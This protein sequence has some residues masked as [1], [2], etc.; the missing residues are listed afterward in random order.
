MKPTDFWEEGSDD[1]CQEC[2]VEHQEMRDWKI[3][4]KSLVKDEI[5][6]AAEITSDPSEGSLCGREYGVGVP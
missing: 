4:T 2:C 1:G 5:A 6:E 3:G